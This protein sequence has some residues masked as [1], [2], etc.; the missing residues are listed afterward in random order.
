MGGACAQ[1]LFW[2]HGISNSGLPLSLNPPARRSEVHYQSAVS[3]R[4]RGVVMRRRRNIHFY[5]P[6][7][8]YPLP[9]Q[10]FQVRC[11]IQAHPGNLLPVCLKAVVLEVDEQKMYAARKKPME[12]VK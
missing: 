12:Q 7:K 1:Q 10:V 5:P 11:S 8:C 9:L 2:L 3:I 6:K 4:C